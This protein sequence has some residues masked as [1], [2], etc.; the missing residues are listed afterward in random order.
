M[1]ITTASRIPRCCPHHRDWASLTR[2]LVSDFS[3]V[4]ARTIVGELA[5]ARH[6]SELFQLEGADALD[7]AELIVRHRV[8][9]ATGCLRVSPSA[10]I[11]PIENAARVA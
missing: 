1:S 5:H 3:D 7:C 4:P 10:N 6:A 11:A 8:L 2:H 9:N